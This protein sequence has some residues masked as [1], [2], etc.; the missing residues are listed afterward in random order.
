MI[1]GGQRG[2]GKIAPSAVGTVGL[3][4]C[5]PNSRNV[6]PGEVFFTIDLR[7]PSDNVVAEMEHLVRQRL[8]AHRGGR[9][10]D[11]KVEQVWDSPAVHFNEDCIAAVARAAE[12]QGIRRADRLRAGPRFRL[13]RA[14]RAD[15]DDLRAVR[16]RPPHNE[17][18][19]TEPEQVTAGAN[20]LLRAVL[21]TDQ[22]FAERAR[23]G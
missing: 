16:R 23:A 8:D 17:L 21:D 18:E 14:R 6:I 11:A 7:H 22:R 1:A 5:R 19:K 2:R 4:E 9:E 15:L 13:C 3:V 20:V 12:A 10:S